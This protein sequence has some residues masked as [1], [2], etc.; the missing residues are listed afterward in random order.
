[1]KF[2][3]TVIQDCFIC[4]PNIFYDERGY[5]LE[6]FNQKEFEAYLGK[7]ID[8]CQ[9]NEAKSARGVLRGLHYQ[10]APFSQV[11]LVR[12]VK[13]K[14]LDV[15]VDIRKNSKTFGQ[16]FALE[17]SETNKKQ[18]FVPAGCAHGYVVLSEEAVF[19]YKVDNYY[20]KDS[21][22]GII[23]NDRDLKIDWKL[24]LS[25]LIISEKDKKQPLFKNAEVFD[26]TK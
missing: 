26:F 16:H 14:V 10:L 24:P 23:F 3:N 1:M 12:V 2:I 17:L 9:D 19:C 18:L 7:E 11:K 21:E 22:R 13:G 15:V 4:E 20:H 8:F 5:F 25:Q 6:S